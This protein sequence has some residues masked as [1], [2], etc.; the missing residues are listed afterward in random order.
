MTF[1]YSILQPIATIPY[2]LPRRKTR[3]IPNDPPEEKRDKR[4]TKEGKKNSKKV[5]NS[6]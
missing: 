3:S 5:E 1:Q 4:K 6:T 2:D